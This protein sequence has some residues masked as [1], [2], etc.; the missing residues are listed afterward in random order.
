MSCTF[1]TLRHE[2]TSPLWQRTPPVNFFGD[3]TSVPGEGDDVERDGNGGTA[4]G[5]LKP[6]TSEDVSNDGDEDEDDEALA[7]KGS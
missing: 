2:I 4:S 3:L 7:F 5:G 1:L 6:R